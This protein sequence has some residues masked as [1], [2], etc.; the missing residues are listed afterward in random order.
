MRNMTAGDMLAIVVA[1]LVVG[2][3][4]YFAGRLN[5][6]ADNAYAFRKIAVTEGHA[7]YTPTKGSPDGFGKPVQDAGLH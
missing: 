3:L 7:V 2:T 4:V 1:V 5:G 6:A